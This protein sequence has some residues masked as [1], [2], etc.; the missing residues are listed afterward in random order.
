[1]VIGVVLKFFGGLNICFLDCEKRQPCKV[2]PVTVRDD[3]IDSSDL[4]KYCQL[5]WKKNNEG[6][7]KENSLCYVLNGDFSPGV[8]IRRPY[9]D[10]CRL[11]CNRAVT[12]V[13]FT[14]D[15][16]LGKVMVEC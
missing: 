3:R 1:M 16:T 12:S 15:G 8:A 4:E 11:E 7:C 9:S 5:C 14:Y 2:E 13:Q 10:Y 6:R